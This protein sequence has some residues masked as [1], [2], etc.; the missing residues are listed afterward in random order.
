M[1]TTR[2]RGRP[3]HRP[4]AMDGAV[5]GADLDGDGEVTGSDLSI[6]L[7]NLAVQET[8]DRGDDHRTN[9]SCVAHNRPY[10]GMGTASCPA[11]VPSP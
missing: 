8:H 2:L 3:V 10:H 4:G 1:P 11:E 6:V 9:R 7:A 5:A